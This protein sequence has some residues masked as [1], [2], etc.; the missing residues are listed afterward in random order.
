MKRAVTLEEISDGK[1]YGL[2]DMVKADCNDCEGCSACCRGMGS[3]ITLDPLDTWRLTQGLGITFEQLLQSHV[4]LGVVDGVILPNLKM[5][6]Q[7]DACTFLDEQGRC[8]VHQIRPGIC[9]LFPLGR[10]YEGD[11]FRYFLQ[12]HEC[13]KDN[14]TKIKVKK[15]IDTPDIQKYETFINQWHYFLKGIQERTELGV[16][17]DFAKQASMYLLKLFYMKAY[18]EAD[19]YQEF[20]LRLDEA[21]AVF[22]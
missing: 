19:F 12:T 6:E 5:A 22:Q 10:Y 16:D 9:R 15:W 14:R 4:E 1:L 8:L 20:A 2:N 7:G 3:S 21:Q 13:K 17:E 18:T 11:S